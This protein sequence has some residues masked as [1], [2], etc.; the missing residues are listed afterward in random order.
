MGVLWS[1]RGALGSFWRGI[2]RLYHGCKTWLILEGWVEF[3]LANI[4]GGHKIKVTEKEK[5]LFSTHLLNV[6]KV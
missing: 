4:I 6:L 5:S 2:E 3:P 1:H